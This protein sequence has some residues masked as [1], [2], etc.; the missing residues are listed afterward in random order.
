METST[1]LLIAAVVIFLVYGYINKDKIA[2]ENATRKEKKRIDAENASPE[3]SSKLR[4]ILE[5]IDILTKSKNIET[6][7]SRYEVA[8]NLL[9]ELLAQYP[10]RL[11]WHELSQNLQR[12]W[13]R[14]LQA[15]PSASIEKCIEKAKVAKTVSTKVNNLGK[16]LL[17]LKDAQNSGNYDAKWLQ[18]QRTQIE[19]LIHDTELGK[20]LEIAEKFEFKED[21]KKAL[22]A[23]Q[24]VL[25]FLK[26]DNIDDSE[27]EELIT[28]IEQKILLCKTKLS[29]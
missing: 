16:A 12:D 26:K 29:A 18:A 8:T 2:R 22:S 24:D 1:M 3:V 9:E 28:D 27:Q 21:F 25:F 5:S 7:R 6:M 17:E 13:K 23:Y 4:V 15:V 19:E 10:H 20:L 11:D 14:C